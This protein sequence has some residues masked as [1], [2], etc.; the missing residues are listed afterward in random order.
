VNSNNNSTD[1]NK[2]VHRAILTAR[3]PAGSWAVRFTS[4]RP[5][6]PLSTQDDVTRYRIPH[7]GQAAWLCSL[8][9]SCEN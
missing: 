5:A 6:S 9:A 1:K 2:W 7:L 4:P 3:Y 8:L